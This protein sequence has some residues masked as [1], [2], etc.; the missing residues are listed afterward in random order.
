MLKAYYQVRIK[1]GNELKAIFNCPLGSFQFRVL[2]FGLPVIFMQLINE[3]LHEHLYKGLLVYLDDIIINI[4]TMAEH[5]NLVRVVLKLPGALLVSYHERGW[6]EEGIRA[7]H[8]CI[9]NS[10]KKTRVKKTR[11]VCTGYTEY[12]Q[13]G[14][15]WM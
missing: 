4:E 8:T 2:L 1:E 6:K 9:S 12:L 10:G 11:A 3:I 15:P 13:D 5:I 7:I 14:L